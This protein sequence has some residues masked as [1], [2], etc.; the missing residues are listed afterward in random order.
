MKKVWVVL[1]IALCLTGCTAVQSDPSDAVSSKMTSNAE[2][3]KDAD[4]VDVEDYFGPNEA[5][6]S[7]VF[8]EAFSAKYTQDELNVFYKVNELLTEFGT[9]ESFRNASDDDRYNM[10]EIILKDLGGARLINNIHKGTALPYALVFDYIGQDEKYLGTG[11]FCVEDWY[12]NLEPEVREPFVTQD[13]DNI[14]YFTPYTDHQL[15]VME[16]TRNKLED[17]Y[18]EEWENLSIE[19][20]YDIVSKGMDDLEAEKLI[21][22]VHW[23]SDNE[24]VSFQYIEPETGMPL[25]AGGFMLI[26][27]DERYNMYGIK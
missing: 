13:I 10:A 14:Y 25:A 7:E 21:R 18:V 26:D 8:G 12:W 16:I 4:S 17:L 1:G 2:F 5:H 3:S 20:R 23:E 9:S 27:F 6:S 15:D 24:S 11:S 19:E 22:W